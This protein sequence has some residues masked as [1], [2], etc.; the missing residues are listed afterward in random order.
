MV[1]TLTNSQREAPVSR[2]R[3]AR[4]ARR[5][6]RRLRIRSR[7]TIAI[8]FLGRRRMRALNKRFLKHDYSTDVLSFRYNNGTAS[9]VQSSGFRVRGNGPQPRTPNP[10]PVVGEI[11]VAPAMARAYARQHGL[12]YEEELSRYVVHGILHWLG[13]EDHTKTQQANMRKMED[14]LLVQ[15]ATGL[16]ARGSG[17]GRAV[18]SLQPRASSR[19]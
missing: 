12:S 7:G 15:C 3:M 5:A 16:G 1:V 18:S 8:T 13:H 9:S 4:L 11:F 6:V 14:R 17:L 19:Q 10:E 2:D